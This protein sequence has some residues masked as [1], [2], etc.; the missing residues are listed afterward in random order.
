MII[1]AV[2]ALLDGDTSQ[3]QWVILDDPAATVV[4]GDVKGAAEVRVAEPI[5]RGTNQ[6]PALYVV[7]VGF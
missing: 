2:I 5:S 6:G 7:Y 3:S 4:E 1:D